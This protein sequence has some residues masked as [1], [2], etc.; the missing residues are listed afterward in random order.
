MN[1][2]FGAL[3]CVAFVAVVAACDSPKTGTTDSPVTEDWDFGDDPLAIRLKVEG[4]TRVF[5]CAAGFSQGQVERDLVDAITEA[6]S[7]CQGSEGNYVCDCK[8][9][10]HESYA[11]TCPAALFETCKLQAQRVDGSGDEP[12]AVTDCSALS[13]EIEGSCALDDSERFECACEG[14]DGTST[15]LGDGGAETPASCDKAL[16]RACAIDCADDFGA[17]SPSTDGVVGEYDCACATNG[18]EHVAFAGSCEAA[19]LWACNPLNQ[20]EDVCTGYGGACVLTKAGSPNELTCTC[21]G[22]TEREVVAEVDASFRACRAT[23]EATCGLGDAA[24]GALCVAEGNGYHAR[25]TRG[26]EADAIMTCEC[27]EDGSSEPRIEQ[28]E[29]RSCDQALLET[30]C[31]ELAN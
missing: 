25:C 7:H 17:C 6:P 20:A 22:A 15:M 21:V 28:V 14:D 19:L 11:F 8:G 12:P 30:I 27:L 1:R 31:P 24:E 5:A 3:V 29:E 2:G 18:F 26:P 10:E 4:S 13:R 9:V 16:F 23:L